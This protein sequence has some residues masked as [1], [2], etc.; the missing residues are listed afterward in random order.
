IAWPMKVAR[1]APTM[2][3]TVV[4]M[5]PLGLFGPGES[6]RAIMPATKPTRITQRMPLMAVVLSLT[7]NRSRRAGV[8]AVTSEPV[9][10]LAVGRQPAVRRQMI[11]HLRQIAAEAVEQFVGRQAALRG[12]RIDLVGAQRL[13]EIAGGNRLVLALAD[14]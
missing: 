2:P 9:R 3:S 7:K 6:M 8:E 5:N 14:P 10:Y 4:R 13:G 11:D 12:Q 1:N